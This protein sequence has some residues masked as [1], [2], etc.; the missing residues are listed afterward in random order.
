MGF[1]LV[2]ILNSKKRE[3]ERGTFFNKE[4]AKDILCVSLLQNQKRDWLASCVFALDG[5]KARFCNFRLDFGSYTHTDTGL[6]ET[7]PSVHI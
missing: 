7:A 1:K 3:R 5:E 4:T 6:C 2:G